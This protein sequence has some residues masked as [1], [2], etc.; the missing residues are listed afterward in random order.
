MS[1]AKLK[2]RGEELFEPL[3]RQLRFSFGW[4]YYSGH[5]RIFDFGC[6]PKGR[7]CTYLNSNNITY[8]Q[9]TGFDPLVKKMV[10]RPKFLITPNLRDVKGKFGLVTMFAVLE[11]LQ[12]PNFNFNFL[13]KLT[14]S[15]SILVI[16]TPSPFG[17][18]F[19]EKLF[20]PL[21][22]VSAR[23]IEEHQHYYTHPEIISLFRKYSF[24]PITVKNFI[25]GMVTFAVFV[26]I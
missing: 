16:T 23:E 6:G 14:R 3:F 20:Y 26:R 7:F 15:G 25:F 4:R 17:R 10:K 13:R 5:D 21:N 1:L 18:F 19:L 24:Q 2:Y 22:L 11:H 12:Y 9:Y 8:S